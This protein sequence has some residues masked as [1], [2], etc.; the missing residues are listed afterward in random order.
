[1]MLSSSRSRTLVKYSPWF[2]YP[3]SY[4]HSLHITLILPTSA[5]AAAGGDDSPLL[6][7]SFQ[8]LPYHFAADAGAGAL[9]FLQGER[10]LHGLERILHKL[11]FCSSRGSHLA[12]PALEL[13]AHRFHRVEDESD[14]RPG[15]VRAFVPALRALFQGIVILLLGLFNDAF[16]AHEPTGLNPCMIAALKQKQAG[17]AA[18]AI[19]ERVYAEKVQ[20]E[21]RG[22]DEG[23]SCSSVLTP[24]EKPEELLH[25]MGSLGG[26]HGSESNPASSIGVCLD[27]VHIVALVHAPISCFTSGEPMQFE[28]RRLG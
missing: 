20:V 15:I 9:N 14:V 17:D 7:H 19:S 11:G 2:Y 1:M 10:P 24:V 18:V 23:R 16:K 4:P 3:F 5:R 13:S 21:R 12:Y 27:D 26:G 8:Y 28:R 22:Q 25:R 6:S